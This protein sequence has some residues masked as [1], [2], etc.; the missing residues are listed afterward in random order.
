MHNDHKL[1]Y[2]SNPAKR[3]HIHANRIRY[4]GKESSN[5]EE[6]L[7]GL[8][9]ANYLEYVNNADSPIGSQV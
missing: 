9:E 6:N 7:S 5:L 2:S 1:D 3:L 4:V 8:E